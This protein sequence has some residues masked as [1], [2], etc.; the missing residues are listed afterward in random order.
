MLLPVLVHREPLKIYIPP[1]SELRFHRPWDVDWGLH[2]QLLDASL[3][4]RE[5][6]RDHARHLD[7]AAERDLAIALR[8][9]QIT[10]A[11]LRTLDVHWEIYFAAAR[12]V[13]DIAVPSVFR[14]AGDRSR[15]L[16]PHFLF[17]LRGRAS[18][19]HV[20]GVGRLSNYA[21]HVRAGLDKLAF[22]LVPR[23]EDLGRRRAAEDAGVDEAREADAGDVARG[24]EDA[25]KVPYRF[26]SA[27]FISI[28]LL[29][30]EGDIVRF[31]VQLVQETA[32]VLLR[33]DAG[34]APWLVLQRLHVLD[35]NDKNVAGLCAL[36]LEGPGEVV[37]LGQ[38][39]IADIVCGVI[40]SNLAACPVDT[41]DFYYFS[42]FDGA[43]EGN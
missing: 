39:H 18:G 11:E 26:C 30:S 36:N 1:W 27:L 5:L 22:A 10:H 34:E 37:D 32:A 16:F 19:M 41:F 25:F 23:S 15:A 33:K 6:E 28:V 35:L 42:F 14:A 40:V 2:V 24:T 3:H 43:G 38:I 9:M 8:E 12:Q 21:V 4:Y 17:D 31:R 29:W 7:S 20:C 13:L